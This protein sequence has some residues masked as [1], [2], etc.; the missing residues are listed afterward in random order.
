MKK[1]KVDD[2]FDLFLQKF[3]DDALD[4]DQDD[5]P[6]VDQEETDTGDED[7]NDAV[8]PDA[9]EDDDDSEIPR[10]PFPPEMDS[11]VAEIRMKT[12][13]EERHDMED[14]QAVSI[15]V[16]PGHEKRLCCSG[17]MSVTIQMK[18]KA[19]V[20]MHRFKCFVY[21]E[22][23]FP[24]CAS[25]EKTPVRR[26]RDRQMT[27]ELPCEHIWVPGKYILYVNDSFDESVMR[28]DFT[29]G[30][31]LQLEAQ[32]SRMLTPCGTEHVLVSCI[33]NVDSDWRAVAEMPGMTQFRRR[34]MQ[35]RQM[36]LLNEF[37]KELKA[38]EIRQSRNL[39]ICIHNDDLN[40]ELL[41]HF[42]NM[43][44]YDYMFNFVDCSTLYEPTSQYPYEQ[45]S[46]KF[47]STVK[48][49]Y[50][51]TRLGDLM[52]A[53]GKVVM[54]RILDSVRSLN[55]ENLLWLCGTRS[56]IDELLEL[57]PSLRQYYE[58]GSYVEQERYSAFDLVQTF[59]RELADEHLEPDARLMDRLARTILQGHEQGAIANWTQADVRRFIACEVRPRY[60]ERAIQ[61]ANAY[62]IAPFCEDDIP[63]DK[64]TSRGSAFE[65]SMRE[66]NGMVGLKDV[67]DGILTMANQARFCQERRQRGLRS[68]GGITY[69]TVFTGNPGT[70]KT[71]VA[72]Q[73]GRMYHSMGLLSKGE[74][75]SVDRTRL[76][77]QYLG[78]TEDNMKVMF[79]EARGNV[80]FIDEAYNLSTGDTD[81]KDF[82]H[83]VI[84]SLLTV[85]T[86]PN[87][88]MLVVLAGY[89]KEMDAMLS[90]NP[91]LRS[92]FP[93]RYQFDDYNADQLM[94][95]ARHLFEREDYIL[96]DEA[97][98][99]LR[100]DIGLTLNMKLPEFGNA[101][102]I[103]QFVH[104][105]I[106]PAMANRV[107][108]TA[109]TDYQHVELSD[110]V[111][112]FERLKPKAVPL[113]PHRKV[114][115]GFS[116]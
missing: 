93:Y 82:G 5:D 71:T 62:E 72:R 3:I 10:L 15:E 19:R 113:K 8:G 13:L 74:L 95:I 108:A 54:R 12:C 98:A 78:Q 16:M 36:V 23:F 32:D 100:K 60:V 18:P 65:E 105:G 20:R 57:Y 88:D 30:D 110:V 91:G 96:T 61:H 51:L 41:R 92:R 17:S 89:T 115:S 48:Q 104:N 11:R 45:I 39:L 49:V 24:M 84:E 101:R 67:K 31:R 14:V 99:E 42:Q 4:D 33:E 52:A 102:W 107:Y 55:D 80:L 46:E 44:V 63:F 116:A 25:T 83:R 90:S 94:E 68:N 50:C 47:S 2:D 81:K 106:I 35:S 43:I 79:E 114:V 112:A 64:L 21:N 77:G 86:R 1:N 76:V 9:S 75:I 58:A 28:I 6:D 73:L 85:L 87:P 40:V 37:R 103:E 97:A 26:L 70:G 29:L 22:F 66:L 38:G 69:H 34:V 59:A 56:E 109:S 7:D 27:V 53:S 111:N